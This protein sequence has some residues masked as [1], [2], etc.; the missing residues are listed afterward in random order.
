MQNSDMHN[1]RHRKPSNIA[2]QAR[3]LRR[4]LRDG[5]DVPRPLD[6]V[7]VCLRLQQRQGRE[8]RYEGDSC[9]I[10]DRQEGA[11][12]RQQR[13]GTRHPHHRNPQVRGLGAHADVV[14]HEGVEGEE[15]DGKH[16]ED[17]DV[18]GG[19]QT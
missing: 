9:R 2:G 4:E 7:L 3:T 12:G 6:L 10:H 15:L 8:Q 16:D 13:Q 1:R 11:G 17:E 18:R 14:A 19:G 5:G